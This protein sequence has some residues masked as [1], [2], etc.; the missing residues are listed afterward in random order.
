MYIKLDENNYIVMM[1]IEPFE[2]AIVASEPSQDV[3]SWFATGKYKF[4][5]GK[6]ILQDNWIEP[7]VKEDEL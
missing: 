7:N 4:I 3:I 5:D 1:T 6:Y 2:G